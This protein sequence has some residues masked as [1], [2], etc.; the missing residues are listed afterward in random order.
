VTLGGFIERAA[1]LGGALRHRRRS[2]FAPGGK[3]SRFSAPACAP[4]RFRRLGDDRSRWSP[5]ARGGGSGETERCAVATSPEGVLSP[6]SPVWRP[7]EASREE[8]LPAAGPELGG[9]T[10]GPLGGP[11]LGCG[12]L[13]GDHPLLQIRE[14][15]V[16][17]L[18]PLPVGRPERASEAAPGPSVGGAGVAQPTPSIW[19]WMP[20][21][22]TIPP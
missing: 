11:L 3:G 4:P 9:L 12:L 8:E 2:A 16:E 13:V 18:D 21:G 17:A 14:T 7:R 20:R 15:G 5:L 10:L 6:P 22:C 19:L 1:E